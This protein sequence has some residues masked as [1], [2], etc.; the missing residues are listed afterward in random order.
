MSQRK[1]IKQAIEQILGAGIIMRD[2]STDPSDELK[3]DFIRIINLYQ[4]VWE[5]QNDL[6]DKQGIDFTSYDEDYFKLIEGLINFCFDEGASDAI[7]FYIYS[8]RDDEDEILPFVDKSGKEHNFKTIDDLW[9]FLLYWAEE[10]M[11]P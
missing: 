11:R 5:R 9:E 1:E 2:D 10:I 7:L 8:K 3:K 4:R 6:I